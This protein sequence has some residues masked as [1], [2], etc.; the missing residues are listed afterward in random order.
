[1]HI[2]LVTA[3]I[4][5]IYVHAGIRFGTVC[6]EVNM[7]MKCDTRS[8]VLTLEKHFEL[9]EKSMD[10]NEILG[11]LRMEGVISRLEMQQLQA[12]RTQIERNR[13]VLMFL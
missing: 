10:C 9:F 13:F 5:Q 8:V 4:C 1:M 11:T 6:T 12:E 2:K 3:V 7:A